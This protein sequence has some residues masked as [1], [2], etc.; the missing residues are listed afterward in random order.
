MVNLKDKRVLVGGVLVL[1]VLVYLYMNKKKK[2]AMLATTNTTTSNNSAKDNY[3]VTLGSSDPTGAVWIVLGGQKFAVN[4]Q[5]A[6]KNY[7]SPV[8]EVITREQL[9]LLKLAG[10][11]NDEGKVV[12]Y[13]AK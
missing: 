7:G 3:A 9:D 13:T 1:G 6:L 8:P 5:T 10:M 4:S 12:T 11:I 2:D